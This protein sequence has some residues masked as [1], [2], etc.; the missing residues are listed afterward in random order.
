MVCSRSRELRRRPIHKPLRSLRTCPS[1]LRKG[2]SKAYGET[3]LLDGVD[4]SIHEGERVGLVGNNGSGK[5]TLARI[6]VGEE[7]PDAGRVARRRE[8]TIRY[9]PQEPILP[10]GRNARDVVL[11]G[12]GAWAEAFERHEELSQLIARKDPGWEAYTEP[13]AAAAHEVERLGGWENSLRVD[14]LLQQLGLRA[15]RSQHR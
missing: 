2:C 10:R 5:S 13:Q 9:L 3:R 11:E 12:L 6:L 15:D 4:L 14:V 7:Q 8:A 1:W